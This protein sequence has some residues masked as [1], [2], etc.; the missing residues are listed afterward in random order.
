MASAGNAPFFAVLNE[1]MIT[2][3]YFGGEDGIQVGLNHLRSS[4]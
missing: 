2:G 1:K 3:T 4:W